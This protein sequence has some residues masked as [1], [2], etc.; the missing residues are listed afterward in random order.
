MFNDKQCGEYYQALVEKNAQYEGVFFAG[1]KTTSIFCR[2][3]CPARKPKFENCEFFQSAQQALLA[4]YRACKRCRPLSYPDEATCLIQMLV[5]AIEDDPQKRWTDADFRAIGVDAS[6]IR[7]QFKKRFGMTF[8]AYARARR[9]GIA[10]K[11]IRQGSSIIQSQNHVG[12]ESASG[13]RD[14]FSKIMGTPPSHKNNLT[15]KAKWIDTP[16]GAMVSM[17]D[18]AALYLLEFVDRRGLEREVQR[19]RQRLKAAIIPGQTAITQSIE[20]E[21]KQ[22]FA[23]KLTHFKTPISGYGSDFQK[24]VWEALRK[25]PSGQTC[26]YLELAQSLGRPTASRAVARANGTNQVAIAIPCHRVI[27]TDGQ[28]GGYAGGLIR[29]QWLI[30]HEKNNAVQK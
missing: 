22:Y 10:L 11:Q 9:M 23:G 6:T 8:I 12:Y 21:L 25:I 1:I 15:L 27:N 7:R 19:M 4:G 28:L 16:L 18:D 24:L 14:A 5:Q 13:F 3:T 2:P 26:S 30:D 17:A 20:Q 29:K